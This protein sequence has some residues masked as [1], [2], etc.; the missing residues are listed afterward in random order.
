MWKVHDITFS[1]E[2]YCENLCMCILIVICPHTCCYWF[3]WKVLDIFVYTLT[4]A[5]VV[6]SLLFTSLTLIKVMHVKFIFLF[7][8]AFLAGSRLRIFFS[9]SLLFLMF[10]VFN[11]IHSWLDF[12]KEKRHSKTVS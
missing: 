10:Q 4:P 9:I 11:S 7:F 1:R 8:S 12:D 5:D 6:G 3:I 2:L